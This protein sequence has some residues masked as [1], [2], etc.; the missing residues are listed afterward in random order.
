MPDEGFQLPRSDPWGGGSNEFY[1]RNRG[2][3][4]GDLYAEM[5]LS[6]SSG[7]EVNRKARYLGGRRERNLPH[8]S[9]LGKHFTLKGSEVMPAHKTGA[10]HSMIYASRAATFQP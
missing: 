1:L 7:G 3:L 8:G 9:K 2:R 6:D 4:F 10:S 5:A